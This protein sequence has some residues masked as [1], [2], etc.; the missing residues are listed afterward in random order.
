MR[1]SFDKLDPISVDR[2]LV[3]A[4]PFVQLP[5]EQKANSLVVYFGFYTKFQL[6]YNAL[7]YAFG[8]C[9]E[10]HSTLRVKHYVDE[11]RSSYGANNKVAFRF[12]LITFCRR[13][14]YCSYRTVV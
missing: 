10:N 4:V 14:S 11:L 8:L 1:N 13:I 2:E 3:L 6:S 12:A 5:T 7:T 9:D